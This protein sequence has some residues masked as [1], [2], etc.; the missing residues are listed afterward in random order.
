M[1]LLPY[2]CNLQAI[3]NI[4]KG[5]EICE[6]YGP[7]FFHSAREDRQVFFIPVSFEKKEFKDLTMFTWSRSKHVIYII[8]KGT[9]K[10][11]VLVRLQLYS[12]HRRLATHA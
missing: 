12:L 7:I 3:K 6:N 9:T 2:I 1:I 10:E 11:A 4:A 8:F 5:E